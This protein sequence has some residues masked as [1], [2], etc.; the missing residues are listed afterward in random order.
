MKLAPVRKPGLEGLEFEKNVIESKLKGSK[1]GR[2]SSNPYLENL[3]INFKMSK[4]NQRFSQKGSTTQHWYILDI[5]INM[6]LV[7]NWY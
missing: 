3:H 2:P 4:P 1:L 6:V 7:L 5:G